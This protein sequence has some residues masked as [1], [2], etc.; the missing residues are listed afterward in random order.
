[1]RTTEPVTAKGIR[2]T[3]EQLVLI[4][5]DGEVPTLWEECSPRLAAASPEQRPAAERSPGGY[6]IH[7]AAIDEDLPVGE[8]MQVPPRSVVTLIT[9]D[10]R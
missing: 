1:M 3:A 6:G 2:T 4:L 8:T 7:W 10:Q 9:A 5:A